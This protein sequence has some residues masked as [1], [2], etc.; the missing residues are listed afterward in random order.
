MPDTTTLTYLNTTLIASNTMTTTPSI[1]STISIPLSQLDGTTHNP[2]SYHCSAV[3]DALLE[4]EEY[5]GDSQEE[6]DARKHSIIQTFIDECD[7]FAEEFGAEQYDSFDNTILYNSTDRDGI[8]RFSKQN[9]G[10]SLLTLITGVRFHTGWVT[11]DL[12]KLV[13]DLCEQGTDADEDFIKQNLSR[14]L[15]KA[16]GHF[17]LA[18]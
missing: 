3:Q 10:V 9:A 15:L 12:E 11:C 13:E 6:L 18:V 8:L 16:D 4:L 2:T 5:E 14:F 7:D 1:L 17:H